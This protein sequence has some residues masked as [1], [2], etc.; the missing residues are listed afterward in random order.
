MC[1]TR[2]DEL[3]VPEERVARVCLNAIP[4]LRELASDVPMSVPYFS[5]WVLNDDPIAELE[6]MARELGP[7]FFDLLRVL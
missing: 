4:P 5:D 3:P 2:P 6:F 7:A 1:S